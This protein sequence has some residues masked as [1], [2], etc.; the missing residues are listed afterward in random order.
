[1]RRALDSAALHRGFAC[2]PSRNPYL[3]S[4][5]KY[6]KQTF[7]CFFLVGLVFYFTLL[8]M[9]K[10]HLPTACAAALLS[11]SACSTLQPSAPAPLK[12]ATGAALNACAPLASQFQFANTAITSAVTVPAGPVS[13][14]A[15]PTAFSVGEH[16]L[17]KGAMHKRMGSDGKDYAIGFEMRLPA[18]WN[19]RFYYQGNGGLDGAVQPALGALG[20]G[21]LT[22]ALAQGF[23]VISSDAGHTGAQ[24]TFFGLE[25]QARLDYGYQAVGK[26]T[27]MA[28]A[29]IASAYGKAPDRSYI[30]G[31]SNGGRHAMV[32][33]SR[34]G[35]Q[36]DGYL[37][38]APGYRLPNAA[39][40]QLWGAQQWQPLA[41]PGATA[42]HPMSAQAPRIADLGT[43]F[44]AAERQTVANAILAKCDALD[45]AKD[46]MVMATQAC[47]AAFNVQRD[48]PSCGGDARSAAGNCLTVAQKTVVAST[49]AGGMANG[50]PIYSAFPLDPGVAGNNWATWKFA[51]SIALDPLFVGTVFSTK[52][53]VAN[54][55]TLNIGEAMTQIASTSARYK[56]SGIALMSPPQH[57][58]PTNFAALKARGAKALLYHGVSDPIFSAEDTRQWVERV[59]AAQG[60]TAANFARYFPVPG[61]N[62]CSMGPATD[63]F[64]MLS[65]LVAWVEQ[66]IAPQSVMA[67]ARSVG[68][69]G[70]ANT[71]LPKDWGNSRQRPLCAYPSVATYT[72][73]D[74]EKASSFVCR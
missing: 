71:E 25:P 36:Y 37:I 16:C 28:K 3:L 17:V 47:Q 44:T 23:A 33:M 38:G 49:Y 13:L 64:D 51:N 48:V 72:G 57:E 63:Q 20:G 6:L 68:N 29:L 46:G 1:M 2:S 5:Q 65:P 52:T 4:D 42:P 50:K 54:P 73:G 14:P 26:L 66:G 8:T 40:A 7:C 41:T 53:G 61:M 55:F 12:A 69:L 35:E 39:V 24:T 15:G 59:N 70:G 62:H 32:A 60:G 31:C 43:A 45:G 58:N 67:T 19:G 18:A 11:L 30:G 9:S 56:E 34:F 10:Q 74:L 27:P 22:G 21:P